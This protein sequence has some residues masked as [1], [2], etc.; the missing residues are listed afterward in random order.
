MHWV[1]GILVR[2][3]GNPDCHQLGECFACWSQ[4]AKTPSSHTNKFPNPYLA[5]PCT[6][7]CWYGRWKHGW[8]GPDARRPWHQDRHC[9]SMRVGVAQAQGSALHRH[10]A[11]RCTI[12][13]IGTALFLPYPQHE[14]FGWNWA[15]RGPQLHQYTGRCPRRSQG[16]FHAMRALKISKPYNSA[17]GHFHHLSVPHTGWRTTNHLQDL[18]A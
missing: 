14:G 15:L 18:I 9:T 6:R 5:S 4:S 17:A 12:T 1:C 16:R 13:R 7:S 10:G 2:C 8:G 3:F 11:R